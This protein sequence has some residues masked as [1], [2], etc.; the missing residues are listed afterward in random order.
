MAEYEVI[1]DQRE[2]ENFYDH[3]SNYTKTGYDR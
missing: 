2:R 1:F 3:S